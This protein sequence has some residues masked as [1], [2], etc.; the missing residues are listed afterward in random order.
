MVEKYLNV[1]T[2][3]LEES[4]SE[5]RKDANNIKTFS[6]MYLRE[7]RAVL[8]EAIKIAF[9]RPEECTDPKEVLAAIPEALLKDEYRKILA[10]VSK[11]GKKL[12]IVP[13]YLQEIFLGI[14]ME[15]VR[16]NPDA[17]EFVAENALRKY[18][19]IRLMARR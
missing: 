2:R 8:D 12:A 9:E 10:Y 17:Y 14:P 19:D 13:H 18:P 16:N 3:T 6:I 7:H 1:D 4:L 11:D 5:V 15:A